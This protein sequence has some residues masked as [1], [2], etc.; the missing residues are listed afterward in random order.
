MWLKMTAAD[1]IKLIIDQTDGFLDY[2]FNRPN[3]QA[4]VRFAVIKHQHNHKIIA[5]VYEQAEQVFVDVKLTPRQREELRGLSGVD[6]G[7]HFNRDYWTTI[8][9]NDTALS[10]VELSNVIAASASLT[11]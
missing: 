8:K 5:M 10:Q 4:G 11:S 9:V 6:P 7:H 3:Q 2:P 1:L